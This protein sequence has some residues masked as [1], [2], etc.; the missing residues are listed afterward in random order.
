MNYPRT[1]RAFLRDLGLSTAALPFVTNLP[2]L[3][4]TEQARRKQR[5]QEA[6]RRRLMRCTGAVHAMLFPPS[7]SSE[8]LPAAARAVCSQARV[9][10]AKESSAS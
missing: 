3:G 5:L 4:F 9:E 6:D 2:C 1:R 10:W 7:T 8:A